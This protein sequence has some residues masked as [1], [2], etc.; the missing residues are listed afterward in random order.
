MLFSWATK[1]LVHFTSETVAAKRT[2]AMTQHIYNSNSDEGN[3]S[4]QKGIIFK[5]NF[6]LHSQK[7]WQTKNSFSKS[8]KTADLNSTSNNPNL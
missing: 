3:H 8:M 1:I 5:S 7:H 2:K 6:K 4:D